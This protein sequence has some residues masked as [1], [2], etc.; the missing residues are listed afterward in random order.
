[1]PS[2]QKY[3]R[4]NHPIVMGSRKRAKQRKEV[5]ELL[6]IVEQSMQHWKQEAAEQDAV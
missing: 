4:K 6:R 2:Q 3:Y 5:A 1:M